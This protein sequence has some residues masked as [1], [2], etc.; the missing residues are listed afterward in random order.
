MYAKN[1]RRKSKTGSVL[2]RECRG[3]L[4]IVFTYGGKRHFLSTGFPNTPL[5]R[6]LAQETAFQ[7]QRDIEYGEFDPTYQKYKPHSALTTVDEAMPTVLA[8]RLIERRAT[9][10]TCPKSSRKS[11]T[12]Q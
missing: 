1:S 6:N 8:A 3:Y 7:I 10:A 5:N 12:W 4:R 9:E 11:A 2:V